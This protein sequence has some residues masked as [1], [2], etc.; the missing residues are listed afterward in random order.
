MKGLEKIWQSVVKQIRRKEPS[1]LSGRVDAYFQRAKDPRT[2]GHFVE[3][4]RPQAGDIQLVSND[5]LSIA[6]H[7]QIRSARI[8]ALERSSHEML[9]SGVFRFGNNP[10]GEFEERLAQ[11]MGAEAALLSQ[12]GWMANVGLVQSL[13]APEVPVYLDMMAHMSLWEGAKS[14][15]A[16]PRPFRHNNPESLE[17]LAIKHGPGVI[18]VDSVYSTSGSICPLADIVEISERHGCLLVVD[19]SHSL[20]V[21]GEAGEGMV[22]ELGLAGRVDFRTASLSKSFAC[23][24]GAIVGS[25]RH[26]EYIKYESLPSIFSSGV[27][28]YEIEGFLAAL[29]VIRAAGDRRRQLR[30]NSDY[31]RGRLDELGYDMEMSR[32]QIMALV[33]GPESETIRLRDA[34]EERG[35]FGSPF[36]APATPRN[37]S[38]IRFSVNAGFGREELDRVA[39]VCR[40]VRDLVGAEEWLSTGRKSRRRPQARFYVPEP[41]IAM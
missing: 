37:R 33:P 19:E 6:G 40:E 29:E 36:C 26:I 32:S 24:G 15:G 8:G 3:G 27:Q 28:E 30:L 9:R 11:W 20:G 16:V 23:R 22:S 41:S 7:P 4:R 10:Q 21:M 2:G 31:L 38:L 1:F 17:K 25:R 12:S 13:A 34:L 18:L 14:A 39:E 35:V 5:Y